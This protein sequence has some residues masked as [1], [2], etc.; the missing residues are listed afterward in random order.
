MAEEPS[1]PTYLKC[2]GDSDCD[3]GY[4]PDCAGMERF[5]GQIVHP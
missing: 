3:G 2:S 5:T 4:M 1:I